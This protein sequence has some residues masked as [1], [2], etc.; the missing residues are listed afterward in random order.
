MWASLS[1][2]PHWGWQLVLPTSLADQPAGPTILAIPHNSLLMALAVS[3]IYP[4]HPTWVSVH[5]GMILPLAPGWM[6]APGH[7]PL[8]LPY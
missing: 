5:P 1:G 7:T 6:E 3:H 2:H 4:Q 8:I